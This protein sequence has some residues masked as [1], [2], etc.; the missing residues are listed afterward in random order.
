MSTK[1]L[2]LIAE[3]LESGE[4]DPIR[5]TL[6][7]S[8]TI[9]EGT[10]VSISAARQK[11]LSARG[12]EITLKDLMVRSPLDTLYLIDVI[13]RHSFRIQG[14]DYHEIVIPVLYVSLSEISAW[15]AWTQRR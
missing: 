7:I 4:Q 10:A 5:L 14:Q 3:K 13:V 8:G 1:H 6:L 2:Q 11:G 12:K 9:V 15:T